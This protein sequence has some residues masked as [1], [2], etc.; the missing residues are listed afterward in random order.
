VGESRAN[1]LKGKR[2]VVTRALEQSESLVKALRDAGAVPI[3]LP[4]VAFGAPDDVTAVD[5]AIRGAAEFDW[6]LLTSQNALRALQERSNI[7]Q[8]HLAGAF[9]GVQVAAVG[10][11]TAEAA[12]NAELVVAYIALKHRGVELAEEL[13]EKLRG[14]R[15]LLPR[16]DRA[17]PDLVKKLGELGA[18]VKDLVAYKTVLPDEQ[19]LERVNEVLSEGADAVL[20]F[21]PSAVHH[22]REVVGEK[23]FMKLSQRAVFAA[24]GPVTQ[25]TLQKAKVERL[26]MAGDTSVD[27]VIT[28]LNQ[29]FTVNGAKLPTGAN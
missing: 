1:A 10:P 5:A 12:R 16:S 3:V 15:V 4:M 23:R 8:V 11:A 6:M 19:V 27:A 17:N 26:V 2:V 22:F 18:R 24:I 9:R 14:K 21:S 20:F 28:A 7:L 13:G 29:H 25:D